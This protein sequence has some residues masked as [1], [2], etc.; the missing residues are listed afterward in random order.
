[1]SYQRVLDFWFGPLDEKGRASSDHSQMW[2]KR[3]DAFDAEIR[4]RFED[5]HQAITSGQRQE[6]LSEP[7]GVLAYVIVLDQFSRNMFRGTPQSFAADPQALVAAQGAIDAGLDAEL[8]FAERSFLY[9]PLMHSESLADQDRC[10]ELF[11]ALAREFDDDRKESANNQ[12]DFA[13][14]HR[15]IIARFGRFPHRNQILGRES[16][17]EEREFLTQPGSSF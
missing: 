9:M 8:A 12:L 13:R 14:R 17:A 11:A 10:V 6:W 16:T 3:D 5:D 4:R 2:W 7:R 15:D 1:M